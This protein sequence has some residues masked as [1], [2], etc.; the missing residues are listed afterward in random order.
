MDH[1]E[2]WN[3]YY[4]DKSQRAP[5]IV[6]SQFAAFVAGEFSY[7]RRTIVE[8]GCGNGRD[9]LFFSRWGYTTIG[10]D[11]SQA[12]IE[13]CQERAQGEANFICRDIRSPD[14]LDSIRKMSVPDDVVVYARFFLHAIG[15]E[16]EMAFLSTA[17]ELCGLEGAVAVE[18]RTNRDEA[19]AKET[20]FHFRRFV[21]P[22]EFMARARQAGLTTTYF[23]E[24][25]GFAKYGKDDAHVARCILVAE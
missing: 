11:A 2:Y 6:P 23:V 10:V 3:S 17:R 14:L 1:E 20:R 25:F 19:L 8:F 13:K 4:S 21:D 24:G 9:S 12:A 7:P 16:E 22:V 18:F 15:L 5:P